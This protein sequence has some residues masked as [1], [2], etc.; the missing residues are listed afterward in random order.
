MLKILIIAVVLII[1]SNRYDVAD[2]TAF[3]KK[4]GSAFISKMDNSLASSNLP[5]P[6]IDPKR[7]SGAYRL[8]AARRS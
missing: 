6:S 1:A 3:A 4:E 7:K 5:V 2:I 8:K